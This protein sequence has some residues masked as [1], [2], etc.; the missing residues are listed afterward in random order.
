MSESLSHSTELRH[1]PARKTWPWLAC[2]SCAA[3]G[4]AF[5][6]WL[7]SPFQPGTGALI[8]LF[9]GALC[10]LLDPLFDSA[11]RW[12]AGRTRSRTKAGLAGAVV[13]VA[14]LGGMMM[15]MLAGIGW[16]GDCWG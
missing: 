2:M 11:V 16:A 5:G 3:G 8:G 7:G 4:A 6:F 10:G 15:I 12:A 14:L 9:V 13:A 1:E